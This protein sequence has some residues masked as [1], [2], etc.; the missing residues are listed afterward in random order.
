MKNKF[1][2]VFILM[3]IPILCGKKRIV[4]DVIN[5][6]IYALYE[7]SIPKGR[8]NMV[9]ITISDV[10]GIGYVYKYIFKNGGTLFVSNTNSCFNEVSN[11]NESIV[12]DPFKRDNLP[13]Y[14]F[15]DKKGFDNING[16]YRIWESFDVCIGYYGVSSGNKSK[17]DNAVE[18]LRS[19]CVYA[20]S[21]YSMCKKQS[22]DIV[23]TPVFVLLHPELL[24]PK[25]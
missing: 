22:E 24:Q 20:K 12:G 13:A 1:F 2:I 8:Y 11:T 23:I 19:I 5:R 21:Y 6:D 4:L 14:S 18:S 3:L 25:E 10:G 7:F 15:I 9:R 17:F 16:Y